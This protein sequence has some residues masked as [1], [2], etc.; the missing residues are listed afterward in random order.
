V[1]A[2]PTRVVTIANMVIVPINHVTGEISM[3]NFAG[4]SDVIVDVLGCFPPA[5]SDAN[6]GRF[7]GFDSSR[8]P[9]SESPAVVRGWNVSPECPRAPRVG[10]RPSDRLSDPSARRAGRSRRR[11]RSR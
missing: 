7:A 3:F 6:S 1:E 11:S 2:E 10:A 9:S 8:R 4:Q 5:S